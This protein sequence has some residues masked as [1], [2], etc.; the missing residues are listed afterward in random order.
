MAAEGYNV[1]SVPMRIL[2]TLLLAA[3]A[4]ALAL[5][6]GIYPFHT[7]GAESGLGNLAAMRLAQDTA[8][9]IWVATQDGV[10]RFDGASFVRFGLEDGLP[11]TFI[12]SLKAAPDG[13]VWAGTGTGLARFDGRRFVVMTKMAPNAIA[14]DRSGRVWAAMP[15][16]VMR[17][18]AKSAFARVEGWPSGVEADAIWCADNVVYAAMHGRLG[19]YDGSAWTFTDVNTTERIDAVVVDKNSVVWK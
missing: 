19:R 14:I 17:G 1:L 12:S 16:G 6:R 9:F 5:P 2:F 8:G 7:Y 13:S 10:Y 18:D 11:S 4:H 15:L 3:S